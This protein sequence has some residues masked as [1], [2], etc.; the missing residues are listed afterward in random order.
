M[1][2]SNGPV[3]LPQKI[4]DVQH[5]DWGTRIDPFCFWQAFHVTWLICSF[6]FCFL[7]LFV[8]SAAGDNVIF[9]QPRI[10]PNEFYTNVEFTGW[11]GWGN[12]SYRV[13]QFTNVWQ[14]WIKEAE[15]CDLAYAWIGPIS[16]MHFTPMKGK[17]K[18]YY[19]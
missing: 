1:A 15:I 4:L 8:L 17:Q 3:D 9:W 13:A 12:E 7:I 14:S 10:Y 5:L 6:I 18:P 11:M 2:L 19:E 16:R